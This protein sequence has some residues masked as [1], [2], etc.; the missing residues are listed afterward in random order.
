MRYEGRKIGIIHA[1]VFT[2]TVIQN[3]I[4]EILPGITVSH[5][6]DDSVQNTNLAAEIGT[7]P[8]R[9][10]LKFATMCG[11]LEDYGC[12][13]IVLGCSTFNRAVE[14]A[15]PMIDVPLLQIDRPMMDE[16][17]QIGRRVGILATLPS[18]VPASERLLGLAAG[19]AG[20]DIEITTRVS[21]AA[22]KELRAGRPE[23]HNEILLDEIES[24]SNEVDSI[25]LAQA[26]MSALEPALGNTRV[27]VLNS[28]RTGITRARQVLDSE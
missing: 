23:K 3:Y 8:K 19:D 28:P 7:I 26:S 24:L 15:Q 14:Y 21:G 9:N 1:A 16:A 20:K 12:E 4:D 17:V 5:A 18:T 2:A 6:G 13:V 27:P 11:W 10:Y 25:V 22:F